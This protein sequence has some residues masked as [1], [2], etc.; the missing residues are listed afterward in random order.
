[1]ARSYQEVLVSSIGDFGRVQGLIV[2]ACKAPEFLG[3]WS[4]IMISFAGAQP[5]QWEITH[6]FPQ[7]FH[8]CK[9][10]SKS[11]TLIS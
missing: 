9:I 7:M 10:N 8:P 1:M 3:V 11:V 6:N 5:K 2:L 4:M